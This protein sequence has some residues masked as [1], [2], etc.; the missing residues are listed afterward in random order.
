MVHNFVRSDH[1]FIISHAM[2]FNIRKFGV[3]KLIQFANG[4]K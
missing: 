1:I 2:G 3:T 4:S